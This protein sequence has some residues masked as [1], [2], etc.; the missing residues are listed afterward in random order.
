[1][2]SGINEVDY[3]SCAHCVRTYY[4]YDT[5]YAEFGC[6]LGDSNPDTNPCWGDEDCPLRYKFEVIED[7]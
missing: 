7:E 6:T 4:E 5:G 2:T 1:M 3:E